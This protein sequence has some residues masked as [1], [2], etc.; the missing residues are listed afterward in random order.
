MWK[1]CTWNFRNFSIR[2]EFFHGG[3]E[4]KE[5]AIFISSSDDTYT[6]RTVIKPSSLTSFNRDDTA[7]ESSI[8][9]PSVKLLGQHV[10]KACE[11]DFNSGMNFAQWCSNPQIGEGA[12]ILK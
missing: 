11:V 9:V 8:T 6:L 3:K 2:N 1:I 10:E 12:L 5:F 4:N 7:N